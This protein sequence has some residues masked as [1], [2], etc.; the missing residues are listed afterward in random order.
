MNLKL[1]SEVPSSNHIYI[2]LFLI[3]PLS[4]IAYMT[5]VAITYELFTII[6]VPCIPVGVGG[7]GLRELSRNNGALWY[8]T[9]ICDG[10]IMGSGFGHSMISHI[11]WTSL[12]YSG[13]F[14]THY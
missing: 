3:G 10:T 13:N 7:G 9:C 14:T 12:L 6:Q 5:E 4:G 2:Y 1:N 8:S 11:H